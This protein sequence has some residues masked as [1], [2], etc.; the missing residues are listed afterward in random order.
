ME[1]QRDRQ[2]KEVMDLWILKKCNEVWVCGSRRLF[3]TNTSTFVRNENTNF[4]MKKPAGQSL[5]IKDYAGVQKVR[6]SWCQ[7]LNNAACQLAEANG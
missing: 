1:V 5:D 3:I 7:A 6:M 4:C 2:G